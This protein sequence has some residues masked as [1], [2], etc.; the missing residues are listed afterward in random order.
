MRKAA[1]FL[2]KAMEITIFVQ[3]LKKYAALAEG[4]IPNVEEKRQC[5]AS[6]NSYLGIIAHYKTY[7]F[8][9]AQMMR[10]FGCRLKTHFAVPQS[11]KK[12]LL[13]SAF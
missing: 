4:H 7:T 5:L 9:K 1:A 13:K 11:V 3:C 12:I 2:N 10:Y 6:V 8:R